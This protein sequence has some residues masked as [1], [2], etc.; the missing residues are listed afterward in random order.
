MHTIKGSSAMMQFKSIMTI[1][2]KVE[3]LFYYIR[4][5]GI[6]HEYNEELINLVFKFTD[7]IKGEISKIGQDIPLEENLES[8]EEEIN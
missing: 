8:F 2:H 7:F 5:N 3:D 4:E 1:S 6:K